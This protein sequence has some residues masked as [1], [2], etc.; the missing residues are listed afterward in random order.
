ME[1]NLFSVL[2]AG[3][4]FW[5]AVFTW[6]QSTRAALC[7][8]CRDKMFIESEGK[9]I[10]CGGPTASGALKLCPKCS[11]KRHQC[12]HCLAA[13]TEK[14]EAAAA[15]PPA[16]PLPDKPNSVDA[17]SGDHQGKPRQDWT[18]P[19]AGDSPT[20]P[21]ATAAAQTAGPEINPLP[22][23]AA[24]TES[25]AP[26]E[27]LP[28]SRPPAD[29]EH[30]VPVPPDPVAAVKLK[31]INPAK[32]GVYTAGKWHY[33]MQILSPGTRSEGRWGWLTYDGQKLPRGAVNDYYNTPW[34]PMYWVD[35]PTSA[36]GLHGWMPVPLAQNRRQGRALECADL[37]FGRRA[38]PARNR[39]HRHSG[40]GALL[41]S[42]RADEPAGTD[43][44]NQQ[45]AQRPVGPAAGR[46]CSR[47]P[48]AWQSGAGL[49]MAGR[50]HEQSGRTADGAAAVFAA[51]TDRRA[52][53]GHG[54]VHVYF[55]GRA[56]RKRLDPPVLRPSQRP[57]SP[58]RFFRGGRQCLARDRHRSAHGPCT[59]RGL[60]IAV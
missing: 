32:A 31:P 5:A 19:V 57:G 54:H 9:C 12:E 10:D 53:G 13:T 21:D 43:A 26:A 58:A 36:W 44:G 29:H 49:S 2:A 34:G 15:G 25:P 23:V 1:R 30:M 59:F 56:A 38:N 52:D 48:A 16:D 24:K 14:D 46:Q 11:A 35:V 60:A 7:S 28:E 51:R 50:H 17:H 55:P 8:E 20:K 47:D 42:C 39:R 33:Q 18:A 37:D 41:R 45:V 22:P 40:A 27:I 6:N 4:V 3:L